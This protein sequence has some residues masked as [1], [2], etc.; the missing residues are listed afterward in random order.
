MIDD[1]RFAN[2]FLSNFHMHA[3]EFEGLTYPSTEH[4]YQ[5]AKSLDPETRLAFSKLETAREAKKMGASLVKVRD[6]W[7]KISLGIME[8]VIRTKFQDPELKQKLLD[9]GDQELVEGNTWN[10]TFW[11]V[12]NGKGENHLGKVLMKVRADLRSAG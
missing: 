7:F 8:Q 12:C 9:T 2:R 11:G 6:D 4:A 5:A 1:F 3:V 10:D